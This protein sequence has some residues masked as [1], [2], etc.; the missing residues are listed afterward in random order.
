[1]STIDRFRDE[2]DAYIAKAEPVSTTVPVPVAIRTGSLGSRD[3][4]GV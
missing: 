3:G 4:A 2:Y 1:M